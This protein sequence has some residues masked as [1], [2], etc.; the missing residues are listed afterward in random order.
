M[1]NRMVAKG[2]LRTERLRNLILYRSAITRAEA[3]GGEVMR[4]IRRAFDGALTP[5]MQFLLDN[6]KLSAEQ[7]K[8]LEAL[9]K[10][11]KAEMDS[12]E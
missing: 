10:S 8:E 5:M 6:N 12:N 4:A 11:K 3:Q 1:M 7:L 9:I 2:L